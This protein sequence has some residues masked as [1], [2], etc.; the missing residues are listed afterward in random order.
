MSQSFTPGA[1]TFNCDTCGK[2]FKKRS[3][4]NRHMQIH[5]DIKFPCKICSKSFSRKDNLAA[6]IS[7]VHDKDKIACQKCGIKFSKKSNLSRHEKTFHSRG[8]EGENI[9]ECCEEAFP[10]PRL[11]QIHV[12]KVHK[13]FKCFEC[14]SR[15]T[16]KAHLKEHAKNIPVECKECNIKFCTKKLLGDHEKRKHGD[17]RGGNVCDLCDKSFS[18]KFRLKTHVQIRKICLCEICGMHL[19]NERDKVLHI[20]RYHKMRKCEYCGTTRS[21]LKFLNTHISIKHKRKADV[22][23]V[24]KP[25]EITM[26][27]LKPDRNGLYT[28]FFVTDLKYP[29]L[30]Q[31]FRKSC[32]TYFDICS[33]RHEGSFLI[34]FENAAD[35][36]A[37]ISVH[38]DDLFSMSSFKLVF[39]Q[40]GPCEER[41][42]EDDHEE[43]DL[44]Q[45]RG[46]IAHVD[47][48]TEEKDDHEEGDKSCEHGKATE[49]D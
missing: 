23:D 6:H 44:S 18:S 29:T 38:K 43:E 47:D 37:A 4:K 32:G 24:S 11:L 46:A 36:W 26:E 1:M 42:R 33:G 28:L 30:R 27:S 15:F 3:D 48:D 10:T 5:E 20:Q 22:D 17:D 14:N 39:E 41:N 34:S 7:V 2:G 9:C 35:L 19:C 45:E 13:R 31:E 21:S 49:S 16:T 12:K 40:N 8:V 25:Q